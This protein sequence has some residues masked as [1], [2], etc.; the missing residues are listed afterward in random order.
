LQHPRATLATLVRDAGSNESFRLKAAL[1]EAMDWRSR[2][3]RQWFLKVRLP[4]YLALI[5][6]GDVVIDAGAHIGAVSRLFAERGARVLAFE[7]HPQAFAALRLMSQ[8]WPA[9]EP[10]NKALADRNGTAPLYFHRRGHGL[11]W[12]ESASL[13]RDKRNVDPAQCVEV[14]TVRLADVV[15][16]VG[17]VRFIKMDIEGAEYAVLAD[18]IDSGRHNQVDMIA[19]ETHERS[20][21]LLPAHG[22]LRARIRRE[23]IRNIALDW[24]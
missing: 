12:A 7:P 19:V 21:A 10:I 15:A 14:E 20:P 22:A 13:M 23:R 17:R 6:P 9:I 3:R 24:I 2:F 1:R 11:A 5:R 4:R 16:D 8:A 18:L